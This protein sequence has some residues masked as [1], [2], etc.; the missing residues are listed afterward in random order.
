MVVY[1]GSAI[2][3]TNQENANANATATTQAITSKDL[4][5][6]HAALDIRILTWRT[7]T[8]LNV[9]HISASDAGFGAGDN[10][11]EVVYGYCTKTEFYVYVLESSKPDGIIADTEGYVYRPDS[12]SA[13]GCHPLNWIIIDEDR[14]A[15]DW[16]FVTISTDAATTT[17][18]NA[19][20]QTPDAAIMTRTP[21]AF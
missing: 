3:Q 12:Y 19:T 9:H 13:R 10:T 1:I 16:S 4:A 21:E 14:A 11:K 18:Q 15:D 8:D 7:V 2:S 20:I 6:M 17:A 5:Q